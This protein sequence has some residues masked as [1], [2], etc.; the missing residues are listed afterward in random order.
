MNIIKRNGYGSNFNILYLNIDNTIITKKTINE[1]GIN[2]LKYEI[3]FYKF[4]ID[5]KINLKIPTILYYDY[6]TIVMKYIKQHKLNIDYF[7]II[8]KN[9]SNLHDY[10]NI[11]VDKSYFKKILF[12]ETIM[13][14]NE[15][16]IIIKDIIEKNNNIKYIN[17]IEL[18]NFNKIINELTN[19]FN[20]Y[21]DNLN[22]YI[23]Q[24]IHGDPQYNNIIFNNNDVFFIDAKGIFGSSIIYGIK[25]Y[26]IAK[27]F[28]SLSGYEIFDNMTIDNININDNNL[29]IDFIN[30]P[31]F[32][33][34]HNSKLVKYLFIT[35]WLSNAHIFIKEPYKA[36][37][38]FYI[39]LYFSTLLL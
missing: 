7:Y 5:N 1:Y 21:I 11:K 31:N 27:I 9:L 4:I 37:T 26:D 19:Y 13:K 39:G 36:I 22:E 2:K 33:L 23:L 3:N 24:P 38:S 35:I 32:N 25:E 12:E 17:N 8:I 20:L 18:L 6:E 16:Y 29:N 30:I 15:R 34:Y 14:I 10:N 28:F